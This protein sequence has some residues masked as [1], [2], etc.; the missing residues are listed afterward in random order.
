MTEAIRNINKQQI[1]YFFVT[2]G[3]KNYSI[4]RK[5]IKF[6]AKKFKLFKNI[7]VNKLINSNIKHPKDLKLIFESI[8]TIFVQSDDLGSYNSILSAID[9]AYWDLI[10]IRSQ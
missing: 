3:D 7:F 6:Q 4:Q 10:A 9:C 8:K 2:Y 1:N 5:R